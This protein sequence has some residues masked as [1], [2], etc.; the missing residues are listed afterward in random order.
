[1][2]KNNG[3][4][5]SGIVDLLTGDSTTI[6]TSPLSGAMR[7][8]EWKSMTIDAWARALVAA[9]FRIAV[10]WSDNPAEFTGTPDYFN[11]TYITA[12]GWTRAT[13]V[14]DLFSIAGTTPKTWFR[15]VAQGLDTS[16]TLAGGGQIRIVVKP[17]P[18]VCFHR[19]TS[20]YVRCNTKASDS[21]ACF[22]P[23][24][25]VIPT[26]GIT[27]NRVV[28]DVVAI[29]GAIKLQ[30]GIQETDT[31]DDPTSWTSVS[32]YGSEVTSTGVTFPTA[33]TAVSFTRR[34]ARY[35][36]SAKNDTGGTEVEA[37]LVRLIVEARG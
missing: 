21:T 18:M 10:Q 16:G 12:N 37:G 1:M 22:T 7:T 34:F 9:K 26:T 15:F 2:N 11:S 31:P 36:M 25:D 29:T 5:D 33:F 28:I 4:F 35:V 30:V 14:F 19:L 32:T 8:G 24:S 3:G 17:S 27:E 20:S 6:T 23:V 13:T